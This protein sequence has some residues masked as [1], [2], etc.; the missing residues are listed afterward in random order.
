MAR[1][2]SGKTKVADLHPMPG[3]V[4]H[5]R[6][7]SMADVAALA[8]VHKMTVSLALRDS[9]RIPKT[10][11]DRVRQAAK[12]LG[13]RKST[14]VSTVMGQLARSRRV[15]HATPLM[16]LSDIPP[17]RQVDPGHLPYYKSFVNGG[18]T[19]AKEL[20]F[21]LDVENYCD[22]SLSHKRL[23]QILETRG[24]QGVV[25]NIGYQSPKRLDLNWDRLTAVTCGGQLEHP[26]SLSRVQSDMPQIMN[27]S[28]QELTA[29]GYERIGCCVAQELNARLGY[30]IE[31]AFRVYQASIPKSRQ[32]PLPQH[33]FDDSASVIPR[34]VRKEKPDAIIASYHGVLDDLEKEGYQAPRDFGFVSISQPGPHERYAGMRQFK[35][36]LLATAVDIVVGNLVGGR[37][38]LPDLPTRTLVPGTWVEGETLRPRPE[39]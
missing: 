2:S 11:R 35:G 6:R 38:G 16:F 39:A 31:G 10:T 8:G 34:W 20:G 24:I 13:Y 28:L 15:E 12:Q 33:S 32:V 37:L 5:L 14:V 17:E 22:G 36:D 27:R 21:R 29:R 1:A 7:P 26:R 3:E 4:A 19:R 9:P 25:I 18:I 30:L 23:N